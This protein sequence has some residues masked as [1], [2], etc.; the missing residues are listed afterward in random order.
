MNNH[1]PGPWFTVL[2]R[3]YWKIVTHDGITIC[4][5]DEYPA[6][7]EKADAYL[8]AAAPEMLELLELAI[9]DAE[10]VLSQKFWKEVREI[11]TK[12]T[13]KGNP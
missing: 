8:C 12:A 10:Y 3:T 5:Y 13:N 11:I 1:T 4:S 7:L 9:G 2:E 6:R